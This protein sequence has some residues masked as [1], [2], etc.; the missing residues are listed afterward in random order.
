MPLR[1]LQLSKVHAM[2]SQCSHLLVRD[3]ILEHVLPDLSQRHCSLSDVP[4]S[5]R[6][7]REKEV[8]ADFSLNI[9]AS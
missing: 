7:L 9:I 6:F 5:T 3:L 2:V 8:N 4:M 1:R